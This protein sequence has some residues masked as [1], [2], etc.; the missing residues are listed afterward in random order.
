MIVAE[1]FWSQVDITGECWLWTGHLTDGY[2]RIKVDGRFVAAHQWSYVNAGKV[3]PD[4]MM[5]DHI[6]HDRACVNPSHLRPVTHKQNMENQ[7]A[8]H[9]NSTTGVRGVFRRGGRYRAAVRNNGRL[10]WLGTYDTIEEASEVARLKRI[11][12]FTHND[13][14]KFPP[15]KRRA[16]T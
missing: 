16:T 13:A 10:Y 9:R 8:A 11:E 2:G 14:D 1:R 6:C 5:L 3:I 7:V 12:L 4:G 15:Q